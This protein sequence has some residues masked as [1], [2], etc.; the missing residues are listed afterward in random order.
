MR[1]LVNISYQGSQFLGFQIQQHGRTIQV[2]EYLILYQN[3][4]TV[5]SHV[6]LC[7]FYY[8]DVF[9]PHANIPEQQWQ[10]AMN[11]ALPDDIYV[12][13]VSF[14]NDDFH[15]RYDCVGKSYR[16]KIYQSAHVKSCVPIKCCAA[17]FIFSISNCSGT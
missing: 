16:Y 3:E 7:R 2:L 14:V 13:D 9:L 8:L 1:V 17:I 10:Y 4:N 6:R 5:Q 11:R 15:C 12:N